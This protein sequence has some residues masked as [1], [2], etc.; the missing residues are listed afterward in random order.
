MAR[1]NLK[2]INLIVTALTIAAQSYVDARNTIA[3]ER[4]RL[5]VDGVSRDVGLKRLEDQ[6]YHQWVETRA[7]AEAIE[8]GAIVL[9]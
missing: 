5:P 4:K 9:Q 8:Q 1:P 3:E 7:L 6:F 2:Q